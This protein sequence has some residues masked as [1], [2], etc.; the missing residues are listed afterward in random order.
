LK[1]AA[2]RGSLWDLYVAEHVPMV[3]TVALGGCARQF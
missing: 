2:P 3:W 1:E